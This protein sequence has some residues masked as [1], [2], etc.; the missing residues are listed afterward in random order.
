MIYYCKL[1][2]T[3][4]DITVWSCGKTLKQIAQKIRRQAAIWP[5]KYPAWDEYVTAKRCKTTK[6]MIP[7]KLYL[8]DGEN[9]KVIGDS[10]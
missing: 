5:D 4:G 1:N 9:L 6:K 7:S 2:E 8:F 10:W 3:G